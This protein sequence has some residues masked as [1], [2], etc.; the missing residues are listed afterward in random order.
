MKKLFT[1]LIASSTA[2][3]ASATN[4]N[5]AEIIPVGNPTITHVQVQI[6]GNNLAAQRPNNFTYVPPSGL[7]RGLF[8]VYMSENTGNG[9]DYPTNITY[10][11]V[12]MIPAANTVVQT[13]SVTPKFLNIYVFFLNDS[14]MSSR[15]GNAFSVSYYD[16]TPKNH[17]SYDF[18]VFTTDE[19]KQQVPVEF[20]SAYQTGGNLVTPDSLYCDSI[21]TYQHGDLFLDFAS[22][23]NVN[24]GPLSSNDSSL[25]LINQA[26]NSFYGAI[27]HRSIYGAATSFTPFTRTNGN[28]AQRFIMLS[29]RIQTSA[30]ITTITPLGV[31]LESFTGKSAG[32]TNT[33][34]WTSATETNLDRYEIERSSDGKN[35]R[36]IGSVS[37]NNPSGTSTFAQDYSF[38]DRAPMSTGYYRLNMIDRN[39]SYSYSPVV[40]ITNKE[41]AQSQLNTYPNP[42]TGTITL[43]GI[44]TSGAG[45]VHV[46]N[47]FGQQVSFDF[48]GSGNTTDSKTIR[49]SNPLSGFY[50]VTYESNGTVYSSKVFVQ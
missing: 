7:S 12:T 49:I 14:M 6:S 30:L 10:G 36:S 43:D 20:C 37:A 13:N 24:A 26:S 17:A 39:G 29:G 34:A 42:S 11:G 50:Y 45:Q 31:K 25:S 33:L 1:L 8:V 4:N 44:N 22:T 35:Y 21:A 18:T 46:L 23:A 47:A 41:S 15:T 3:I 40:T 19:T 38:T 28:N 27:F 2:I 16:P 48:V 5:I 32:T 9:M